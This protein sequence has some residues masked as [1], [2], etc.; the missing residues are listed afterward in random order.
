MR[1]GEAL[2]LRPEDLDFRARAIWVRRG[3]YQGVVSTP[4]TG[5]GRRVDMSEQLARV[6]QGWRTLQAAEAVVAGRPQSA[7]LFPGP[8]GAMASYRA[9]RGRWRTLQRRAGVRYRT[10]H[11]LRH[12]FASLLLQQGEALVYV[13]DQLGHASIRLTVDT[14]GHLVPGANRQAVNRLDDRA[15]GGNPAA[16]GVADESENVNVGGGLDSGRP[17][18][19]QYDPPWRTHSSTRS[20]TPIPSARFRPGRRSS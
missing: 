17:N 19:P 20:G 11:Q 7:W 9:V 15:T 4:K 10:L 8:A 2:A 1:I 16:T 5:K 18:L 14:Y 13:R 3:V 6:L 12:T